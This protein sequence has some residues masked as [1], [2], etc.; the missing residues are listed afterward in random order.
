M[1]K[2]CAWM[3]NHVIPFP[4]DYKPYRGFNRCRCT[5]SLR[6][7]SANKCRPSSQH[8]DIQPHSFGYSTQPDSHYI[9]YTAANVLIE[10]Y[11]MYSWRTLA[12][13]CII[14]SEP[15]EVFITCSPLLQCT[16]VITPQWPLDVPSRHTTARYRRLSLTQV[17]FK[18]P[19]LLGTT[20]GLQ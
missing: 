2:T 19:W 16:M 10:Y 1:F 3:V 20:L 14:V 12:I 5:Q 18:G 8:L 15:S 6:T 9:R 4:A 17:Y 11:T 13:V 7:L